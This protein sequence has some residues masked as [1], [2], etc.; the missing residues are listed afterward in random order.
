MPWTGYDR[1]Y[2][3][4]RAR[5]KIGSSVPQLGIQLKQFILTL[6]LLSTYEQQ[7][8]QFNKETCLTTAQLQGEDAIPAHEVPNRPNRPLTK[9]EQQSLDFAKS[10]GLIPAQL[11]GDEE[12]SLHKGENRPK[13]VLGRELMWS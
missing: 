9:Y 1:K 5:K 7:L 12:I 2:S 4:Q 8:F 6:E 10:A 3:R 13:Y 11:H